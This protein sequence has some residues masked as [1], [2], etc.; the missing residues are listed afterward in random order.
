MVN[1]DE[2]YEAFNSFK[3]IVNGLIGDLSNINLQQDDVDNIEE[4][5]NNEYSKLRTI[6]TQRILYTSQSERITVQDKANQIL[7][8]FQSKIFTRIP[9]IDPSS[10]SLGFE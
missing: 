4:K 9:C 2:I 7:L 3:Y 10:I 8:D 1:D 6:I 5:V